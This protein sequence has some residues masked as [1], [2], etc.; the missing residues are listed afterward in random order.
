MSEFASL[1][2]TIRK[3]SPR[4]RYLTALVCRESE[5]EL[6]HALAIDILHFGAFE[7]AR[8]DAVIASYEQ[9]LRT[10]HRAEMEHIEASLPPLPRWS[11]I[12]GVK[13]LE[14]QADE[15]NK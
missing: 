6:W 12:S 3:M 14:S 11:E 7:R 10:A 15:T 4:Q 1:R 2:E 13:G 8:E 5:N 9:E